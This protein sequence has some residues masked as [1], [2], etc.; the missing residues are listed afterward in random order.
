[1]MVD[2]YLVRSGQNLLGILNDL[3]RRPEDAARELNVPVDELYGYLRGEKE[4]PHGLV[5]TAV[6]KWPVN[7]RDFYVLR[8]D[9]PTGVKIMR[10]YESVASSRIMERAGK[11]YYEY[12]D[13]AAS[14]VAQFRPEW[15]KEL[16]VVD[17]NDPEN[18]AAQWNNGHFMHQF[19]Y[20]V[21]PVN[22]Y[23]KG[24]DGNKQVA[25]M[26]TGDSMYITPFVPHTFTSRKNEDGELG[27]I[28]AL[29]YGNKL[30]GETQQELSA[31]GTELAVNYALDFSTSEKAFSSL[32]RFHREAATFDYEALAK[33]THLDKDFLE[34]YE[35]GEK[36][37]D[38]HS[39]TKIA[40]ALNVDVREL[41]P[42]EFIQKKVL[43]NYY[44]E[45]LKH[46][47]RDFPSKGLPSYHI[48]E[49]AGTSHLPHSKALELNVIK[50]KDIDEFNLDLKV[51]LHQYVYNVG[52][53]K[54]GINWELNG[55]RYTEE[56]SPNDSA[57]IKPFVPHNF[58]GPDGKLLVLR[59]GGRMAGEPQRELSLI[60]KDNIERVV[61]EKTQWFNKEGKNKI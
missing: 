37:I 42:P 36:I 46:Y 59:I 38:L 4:I 22:F 14:S 32:L 50:N 54:V 30:A 48:V 45:Q 11:P 49:L 23:Y 40:N 13:T 25:V 18:P 7:E 15:I 8:D 34:K 12:R 60:S 53:E 5:E 35:T 57:Y 19:T 31:I 17:D 1:M 47:S 29:T 9:A 26:N 41:M 61:G 28:L 24:E 3:K 27:L 16:C 33:E 55:K 52:E 20:F 51:G 58:R 43:V 21:G 6:S 39:L 56:I 10:A 44:A 2:N